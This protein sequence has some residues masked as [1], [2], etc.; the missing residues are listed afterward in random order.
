MMTIEVAIT[1]I[2]CLVGI[3]ASILLAGVPWAYGVH[4]RLTTIE[5]SLTDNLAA[6]RQLPALER[7]LTRLELCHEQEDA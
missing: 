4:G 2:T 5:T 3:M 7:R 6:A 1:A